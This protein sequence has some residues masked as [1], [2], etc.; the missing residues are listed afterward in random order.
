MQLNLYNTLNCYKRYRR[1]K[2]ITSEDILFPLTYKEKS[3]EN[4]HNNGRAPYSQK[5]IKEKLGDQQ[6]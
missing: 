5:L 6:I 1:F 3:K 2:I 4:K